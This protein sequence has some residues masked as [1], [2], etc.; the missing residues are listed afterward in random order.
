MS[1]SKD[2]QFEI[3]PQVLLKAYACGIFP[4]AESAE[5]PGLF[6]VEPELRGVIPLDDFH[7]PRSLRKTLKRSPFEIR[8]DHDFEAVIDACA[9][10]THDRPKTWINRR[11]RKLYCDLHAIGHCHSVECWDGGEL[12][13]GLYGVRLGAAFFGESMFSRRTDASKVALVHLVERL[14]AGGFAL[15]DTQ[16]TTKH[17]TQFGAIDIPR[18]KYSKML[19]QAV[20]G[21][22]DFFAWRDQGKL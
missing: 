11:I 15:L 10:S 1:R 13:G 16:F 6:W 17:L 5:D 18:R 19:E 14:R 12:A 20:S 3:T 4:M 2:A 8:I 7:I 9:E 21:N 22:A